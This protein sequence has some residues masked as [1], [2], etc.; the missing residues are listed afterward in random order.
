[1]VRMFVSVLLNT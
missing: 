1:M